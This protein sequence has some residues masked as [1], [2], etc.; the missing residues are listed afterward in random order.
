MGMMS[1]YAAGAAL[2][3]PADKQT[4]KQSDAI[5]PGIERG[6]CDKKKRKKQH[7]RAFTGAFDYLFNY[8][9]NNN[10]KSADRNYG[11]DF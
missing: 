2:S 1:R 4:L 11:F 9:E 7:E 8:G 3:S 6:Y 10:S 5:S